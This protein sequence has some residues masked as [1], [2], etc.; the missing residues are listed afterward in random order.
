MICDIQRGPDR[1][2]QRQ[3]QVYED[4]PARR[5]LMRVKRP[6]QHLVHRNIERVNDRKRRGPR[7]Q[8]PEPIGIGGEERTENR[9]E[10]QVGSKGMESMPKN[11][12]AE[13]RRIA[14][15]LERL[16]DIRNR[17]DDK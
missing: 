11:Y 6:E 3:R 15:M 10:D 9:S 2:R 13:V 7:F 1:A 17:E 12:E 4:E 16:G 14:Q 8:S 5:R